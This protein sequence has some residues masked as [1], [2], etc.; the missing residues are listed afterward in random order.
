MAMV[1]GRFKQLEERLKEEE[2]MGNVEGCKVNIVEKFP[3]RTG[4]L[5]RR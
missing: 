2:A 5:A 1:S 3:T 4:R